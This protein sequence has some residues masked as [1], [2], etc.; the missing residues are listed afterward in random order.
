MFRWLGVHSIVLSIS[1]R[2]QHRDRGEKVQLG[3]HTDP[4]PAYGGAHH[5][6]A[7]VSV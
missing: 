6:I 7:Q 2:D 4:G 1:G 3:T 5:K